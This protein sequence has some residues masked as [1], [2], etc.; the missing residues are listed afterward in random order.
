MIKKP[1]SKKFK[2]YGVI[3]FILLLLIFSSVLIILLSKNNKDTKPSNNLNYKSIFNDNIAIHDYSNHSSREYKFWSGIKNINYNPSYYYTTWNKPILGEYYKLDINKITKKISLIHFYTGNKYHNHA[4]HLTN[5]KET[6]AGK[7][8]TFTG[9]AYL[10]YCIGYN[11]NTKNSPIFGVIVQIGKI[12]NSA[13]K[14]DSETSNILEPAR[15]ELVKSFDTSFSYNKPED[16]NDL[17]D[18]NPNYSIDG[19]NYIE[20]NKIIVNSL[21]KYITNIQNSKKFYF[22]NQNSNAIAKFAAGK[23]SSVD[24]AFDDDSNNYV[25]NIDDNTNPNNIITIKIK[26]TNEPKSSGELTNDQWKNGFNNVNYLIKE[27]S[28]T[29]NTLANVEEVTPYNTHGISYGT[30]ISNFF[31]NNGITNISDAIK[32]AYMLDNY[33]LPNYYFNSAAWVE[34]SE[35]CLFKY[36]GS[37]ISKPFDF[38]DGKLMIYSNFSLSWTFTFDFHTVNQLLNFSNLKKNNL[39]I[40]QLKGLTTKSERDD[41]FLI[42]TYTGNEYKLYFLNTIW[43]GGQRP[44]LY[45]PSKFNTVIIIPSLNFGTY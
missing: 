30:T 15:K 35:Y 29:N 24:V 33:L 14:A 3:I 22:F 34:D 43:A 1:Y 25:I 37:K 16:E 11:N 17:V 5:F 45:V 13:S 31:T 21:M 44:T 27:I 39:M 32:D 36:S 20:T 42:I 26:T 9:N 6:L 8:I 19:K 7:E 2:I 23:I 4:F 12:F 10:I 40:I 28:W 38:L 41:L 18:I